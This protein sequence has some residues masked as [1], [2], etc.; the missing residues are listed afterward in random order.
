M[1]L[2]RDR[3]D[4]VLGLGVLERSGISFDTIEGSN[5][6]AQALEQV[7]DGHPG[8]DAMR[9]DDEIRN[10]TFLSEGHVL[11]LVGH[12]DGTFLTVPGG[13]LV[14]NLWDPHG[15]HL[16]LGEGLALLVDG[17]DNRVDLSIF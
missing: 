15:P 7:T 13:E 17:E 4:G 1:E 5:L 2:G 6:G 8:G 3:L 16:D 14:S 9:V 10:D 11:L 12:A